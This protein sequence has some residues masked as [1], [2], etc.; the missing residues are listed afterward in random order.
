GVCGRLHVGERQR[1]DTAERDAASRDDLA[2]EL[3][4]ALSACFLPREPR[5]ARLRQDAPPTEGRLSSASSDGSCDW[6]YGRP[7]GRVSLRPSKR[8][9]SLNAISRRKLPATHV[10]V[11]VIPVRR[12]E[13]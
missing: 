8:A 3:F 13:E 9:T 5:I 12:P 4:R 10:G 11:R 1:L 2:D 7:S 6:R